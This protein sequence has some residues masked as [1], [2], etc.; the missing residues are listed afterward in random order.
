M[1]Y[2]IL[3]LLR[4]AGTNFSGVQIRALQPI[5]RIRA[6]HCPFLCLYVVSPSF[7]GKQT[8]GITS[9]NTVENAQDLVRIVT[10]GIR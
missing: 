6:P 5:E 9:V 1:Y 4:R 2:L 7:R 10:F 3:R 8:T